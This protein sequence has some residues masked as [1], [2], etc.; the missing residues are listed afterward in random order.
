MG[1]ACLLPRTALR[2]LRSAPCPVWTGRQTLL[3]WLPD[4]LSEG[5]GVRRRERPG[6]GCVR[7]RLAFL[8]AAARRSQLLWRRPLPCAPASAGA[9]GSSAAA[10]LRARHHPGRFPS[11]LLV[12]T[13][14]RF[15]QVAVTL[16]GP[17]AAPVV[18]PRV[19]RYCS[20]CLHG[21]VGAS[22]L[23]ARRRAGRGAP[24][25]ARGV[26]CR[27][28]TSASEAD[29]Q[30]ALLPAASGPGT[31]ASVLSARLVRGALRVSNAAPGVT[32]GV[33]VIQ[34]REMDP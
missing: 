3:S 19:S 32:N 29:R 24:G 31:L 27:A 15:V 21:R 34:C 16:A 9:A 7:S 2:L 6:R 14:K 23:R 5:G 33:H 12:R 1:S 11:A 4:G 17:L 28:A 30:V 26:P 22:T 8:E 18:R 13:N 25:E 20:C 10:T